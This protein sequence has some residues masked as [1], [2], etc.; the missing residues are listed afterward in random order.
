VAAAP[1]A[2]PAAPSGSGYGLLAAKVDYLA[3]AAGAPMGL[4][5]NAK[6]GECYVQSVVPAQYEAVKER[7]IKKAA[8][9]RIDVVPA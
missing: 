5:Q 7:L 4:P 3:P 9:T 6:P 8:A 1:A 2:A